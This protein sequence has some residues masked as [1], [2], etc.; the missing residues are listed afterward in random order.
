[1]MKKSQPILPK[2]I[3]ERYSSWILNWGARTDANWLRYTSAK[4]KW[5]NGKSSWACLSLSR[6][7]DLQNELEVSVDILRQECARKVAEVGKKRKIYDFEPNDPGYVHLGLMEHVCP[8]FSTKHYLEPNLVTSKNVRF[9]KCYNYEKI[10]FL[11]LKQPHLLVGELFT[12][13]YPTNRQ[14][15]KESQVKTYACDEV[16]QAKV[17]RWGF[18]TIYIPPHSN[19]PWSTFSS[20]VSS[21]ASTRDSAEPLWLSIFTTKN[22]PNKRIWD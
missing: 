16:R 13:T 7:R 22:T 10:M 14:F 12:G 11:P 18:W 1:M 21:A 2:H 17:A 9:Y 3:T 15:K 19:S 6:P 4:E 5:G 20:H 8:H